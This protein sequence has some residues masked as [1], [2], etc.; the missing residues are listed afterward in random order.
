MPEITINAYQNE[1][2][3]TLEVS[4]NGY[5]IDIEKATQALNQAQTSDGR[6]HVG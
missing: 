3:F 6:R 1:E 4:D 5:G 2:S